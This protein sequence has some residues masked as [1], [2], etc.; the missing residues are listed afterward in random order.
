[1]IPVGQEPR[2]ASRVPTTLHLT[3]CDQGVAQG[4]GVLKAQLGGRASQLIH[5]V[6]G[7]MA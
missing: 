5:V 2:G 4:C 3:G 6:V 7:R 1:M